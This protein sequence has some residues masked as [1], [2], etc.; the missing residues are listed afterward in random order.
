MVVGCVRPP[1][2]PRLPRRRPSRAG[3]HPATTCGNTGRLADQSSV[4]S[5]AGRNDDMMG[6]TKNVR[7]NKGLKID[8]E[9]LNNLRFGDDVF[10]CTGTPEDLQQ[11]IVNKGTYT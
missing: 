7:E 6:T 5:T 1:P 9:F 8:E 10:L 3:R 2:S 4:D 11:M